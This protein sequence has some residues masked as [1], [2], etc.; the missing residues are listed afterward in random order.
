[1]KT[2]AKEIVNHITNKEK[3]EI[4]CRIYDIDILKCGRE[5]WKHIQNS[6]YI[7]KEEYLTQYNYGNIKDQDA[8]IIDEY[9]LDSFEFSEKQQ[10][11]INIALGYDIEY[12][13]L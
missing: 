7:D 4:T 2:N 13:I 6:D 8:L 12:I 9:M 1:M 11:L 3:F 5:I 10:Q